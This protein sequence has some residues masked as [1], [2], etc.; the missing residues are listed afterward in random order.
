MRTVLITKEIFTFNELSDDAKDKVRDWLTQDLYYEFCYEDFERVGAIMGI[1]IETRA[2]KLMNGKVRYDPCIYWSG[3]YHQGSGLA[4]NGDYRYAKGAVKAMKAETNDTELIRIAQALQD[5]QRKHF[6]RLG[7]SISNNRDTD[8]RVEVFD[9]E[10]YCRDI[11]DAEEE[12]RGLI[13]DFAQW[14]W[15]SLRDEYEYH[16]SEEVIAETCMANG[17][18]FD[19]DGMIQ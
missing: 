7:A 17:Y 15:C 19:E 8:I 4:F 13:K 2:V 3:F 6:Y 11:G 14:C 18:E 9:R 10:D 1:T 5:V 12:V 16:C